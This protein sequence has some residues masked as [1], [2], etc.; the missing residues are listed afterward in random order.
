MEIA[1][2]NQEQKA[3]NKILVEQLLLLT[4]FLDR[5]PRQLTLCNWQV[6]SQVIG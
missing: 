6:Q 1:K 4:F 2:D 3:V 5:Y